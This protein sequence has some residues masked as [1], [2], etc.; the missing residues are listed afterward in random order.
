MESLRKEIF[1]AG[2]ELQGNAPVDAF[3]IETPELCIPQ[4]NKVPR[5]E[6]FFVAYFQRTIELTD[7]RKLRVRP[8]TKS[9]YTLYGTLSK[10]AFSE[11]AIKFPNIES[12]TLWGQNDSDLTQ[13][14]SL[15]KLLSFRI[16]Y[17]QIVTADEA[18]RLALSKSLEDVS[19]DGASS[20]E[21]FDILSK[22]PRIKKL[23]VS[24]VN[25]GGEST[26]YTIPSE[27]GPGTGKD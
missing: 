21:V 1:D 4:I 13:L 10:D 8:E 6:Q 19:I 3:I 24:V 22:L 17:E 25:D 12:L 5:I 14:P 2:G 27:V 15:P 23:R 7:F 26:D 11:L 18:K 16:D 9:F 20:K